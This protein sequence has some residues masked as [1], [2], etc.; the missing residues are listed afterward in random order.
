ML[1]NFKHPAIFLLLALGLVSLRQRF[2]QSPGH[3][4]ERFI[5][6][7]ASGLVV[8]YLGLMLIYL[9]KPNY[10]DPIEPSIT[11]VAQQLLQG[12]QIYHALEAAPRFSLLY[13]PAVFIGN[14][15]GLAVIDNPILASK[16]VGGVCASVTLFAVYQI[17]RRNFSQRLIYAGLGLFLVLALWQE[18][19]TYWNRADSLLLA[20][21]SLGWLA[22]VSR[23]RWWRWL[24]LS[25]AIGV[26]INTKIYAPLFFLPLLIL[27]CLKRGYRDCVPPLVLAGFW[28]GLPFV[29]FPQLFS[30]NNYLTWLLDVGSLP[31]SGMLLARNFEYAVLLAFWP[32]ALIV[33][34][35][36][37]IRPVR[38]WLRLVLPLAVTVLCVLL[39]VIIGAHP[40]AGPHHLIPLMPSIVYL[41]IE[42]TVRIHDRLRQSPVWLALKST[43]LA[44][45]LP[46]WISA[47]A[48]MLLVGQVEIVFYDFVLPDE[49][50]IQTDLLDLSGQYRDR[51]VQMGYGNT[52]S[53][54]VTYFR[55]WLY[56]DQTPYLLDS[57]AMMDMQSVGVAIPAAT[58]AVFTTQ[59]FDIWLIPR[60][61]QPFSMSNLWFASRPP[62]F[63]TALQHAFLN[64]YHLVHRSAFF[65]VWQANRLDNQ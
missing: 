17:L 32:V 37:G 26:A 27:M 41:A 60:G 49:Y 39:L 56:T 36:I 15:I 34:A 10:W 46:A 64:N 8:I 2:V 21:T 20:S 38:H 35:A 43:A 30:V 29:L 3:W 50:S 19:Y 63:S 59:Q 28:A 33:A 11:T 13:G 14:A 18:H 45:L 1:D 52:D 62:L 4:P 48:V 55:P 44:V 47:A 40:A 6:A 5:R 23:R 25:L 22:A 24:G 9:T 42:L 31:L 54:R 58:V 51:S 53:H 57:M 7:A 61:S 16:V 65:D 12:R